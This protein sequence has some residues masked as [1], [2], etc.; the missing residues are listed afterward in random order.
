MLR[1]DVEISAYTHK[2][3]IHTHTRLRSE[4]RF[5][6]DAVR[7][8]RLKFFVNNRLTILPGN[9]TARSVVCMFVW[10]SA[11]HCF[12]SFLFSLKFLLDFSVP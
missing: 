7:M 12:F 4:S 2:T 1:K 10:V 5:V 3:H 8:S 6:Q 11:N 9:I